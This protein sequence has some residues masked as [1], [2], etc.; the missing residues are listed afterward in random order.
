MKNS[1][2]FFAII[3]CIL[4]MVFTSFAF[5]ACS[6]T[7]ETYIVKFESNGGTVYK[8]FESDG[9][10]FELPTPLKSGYTFIA[11]YDNEKFEGQ[12]YTAV[13]TPTE[14]VTLYARWAKNA[15]SEDSGDSGKSGCFSGISGVSGGILL[16][17]AAGIAF[18]FKKRREEN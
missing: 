17:C 7:D 16:I 5:V 8:D 6:T 11:W 15:D 18:A 13:Y 9:S 1:K 14:N 3:V 12:G 4:T 2:R 10:E